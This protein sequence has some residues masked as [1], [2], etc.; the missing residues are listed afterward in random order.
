MRRTA[1]KAAIGV[2]AAAALAALVSCG[3]SSNSP[4]ASPATVPVPSSVQST[5]GGSSIA[6]FA[7]A[8]AKL[9][10]DDMVQ[11]GSTVFVIFQD[12]NDNPDGTIVAGTM[13]QS[14]VIQYDL[15]GNVLQ[16]YNVPGHP[17]GI[18]SPSATSVWVGSNEDGNPVLSVIDI[19][20]NTLT[21]LTPDAASTPLPH[22][23]GLDDMK[24]VNGVVYA[25]GS[26]PA[27]TFTPSPNLAPYSTDGNG[28]TA[29]NGVN[30]SPVLYAV[31]TN[32]DGKTFHAAPVL[33]SSTPTTLLPANTAVTLNMTDPDSMAIMPNGD[34]MIDS[35]GD[36]ELVFVS[37]L[38]TPAQATS[39]LPLTLYGNPWPVDDTKWAPAGSSFML[40][41]DN[42]AGFIY[43]I[44]ATNGFT[45]GTAYSAGQGT[46]LVT[47]MTTGIMKPIYVGMKTPHG[48]LFVND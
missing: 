6:V 13:P 41:S 10:P 4:P 22:G 46:L 12:N 8:P 31:S 45:A 47:D 37:G 32:A 25:S 34:L 27:L 9:R 18:V 2:A 30:T 1:N 43:K 5:A 28:S 29:I 11:A 26:N 44:T 23:G 17:D 36:S 24:L 48:I 14:L 15:E 35:Q 21:T 7:Q 16:T 38:G 20:T 3:G 19:T 39:V 40:L 33:A 42:G